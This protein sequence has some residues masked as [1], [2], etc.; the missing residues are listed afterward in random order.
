VNLTPKS[1]FVI[2]LTAF[3][4][5]GELD[6][7]GMREHFRR[8]GDA[9]IGV[10]VAGSGSGEA[11]TLSPAER[12][13]V[14]R[15]AAEELKGH[16]QVRAM[17]VEPRTAREMVAFGAAVEQAGLDAMQIYPLDVGHGVVPT[18]LEIERYLD[19]V[20]SNVNIPA[21]VATH[22]YAGYLVPIDVLTDVIARHPHVIGINCTVA[23]GD[24][25]YLTRII[26]TFAADIEVH[27]GGPTYALLALALGGS[28]YLCSEGNLAPRLCAS[29]TD[30]FNAGDHTAAL[31]AY[32]K[33][34]RLYAANRYGS[35]RGI[36]AALDMLGLPGGH[37]RLPRLPLGSAELSEVR[38]MLETLALEELPHSPTGDEPQL[39]A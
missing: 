27:V 33:V 23:A 19:E 5:T 1:T 25:G 34:M 18:P 14:L 37:P 39:C 30:H 8:L 4:R 7:T 22:Q 26:D 6:E 16:T 29:V 31:A 12:D 35:I 21:V 20:L 28:G 36:K 17:G 2:S 10:Y 38:A 15:V 24:F 3:T 11:H 32:A 13:E 9:R